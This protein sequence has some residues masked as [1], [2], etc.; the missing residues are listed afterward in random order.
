MSIIYLEI[1]AECGS[2]A[3]GQ[4]LLEVLDVLGYPI[5]HLCMVVSFQLKVAEHQVAHV[6]LQ[7]K[8]HHFLL[9]SPIQII[10]TTISK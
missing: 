5:S 3:I 9:H 1:T 4:A 2:N 7:N 6:S 10:F 8:F